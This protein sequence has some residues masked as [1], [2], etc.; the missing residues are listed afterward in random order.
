MRLAIGQ[1][2]EARRV[3]LAATMAAGAGSHEN[4]ADKTG[5]GCIA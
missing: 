3:F 4:S 2:P 1:T 5:D